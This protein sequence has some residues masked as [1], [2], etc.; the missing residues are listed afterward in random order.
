MKDN[1]ASL[2]V[3]F[4]LK[5]EKYS[6][7]I[8]KVIGN[9]S[10]GITYLASVK[11]EGAL[12]TIE[13]PVALKE[14][15]MRDIN[16]RD[17]VSVTSGSKN[18]IYEEYKKKFV[19]E[20]NNLSKLC[21]PN[22]IKVLES[23]E[24]NNTIYYAMEYI[25]GGDLDHLISTRGVLTEAECIKY[26]IQIA[27]ALK[28]MHANDMLHLD[29][30]PKNIMMRGETPILIDFGLSKQYDENGIPESS[31][32]VGS[33]TDGY[34]PIEQANYHD[35]KDFPVT[36]DIYAF[37][38]TMFKMLTGHRPPAASDILN[39]GFPKEELSKVHCSPATIS[40]IQRCMNPLKKER[41]QTMDDV[42]KTLRQIPG[43][44]DRS[45]GEE[46]KIDV[47]KDGLSAT[48]Q[49]IATAISLK[50]FRMWRDRNWFTNVTILAYMV[51]LW[52]V[53]MLWV[54]IMMKYTY[55]YYNYYIDIVHMMFCGSVVVIYFLSFL[56]GL[57][58]LRNK[59]KKWSIG[60][61]ILCVFI[62]S[63][64]RLVMGIG[65]DPSFTPYPVFS[66]A[67]VFL[68]LMIRRRGL[69]AYYLLGKAIPTA[70]SSSIVS[71]LRN[72]HWLTNTITCLIALGSLLLGAL[73]LWQFVSDGDAYLL[74]IVMCA[75]CSLYYICRNNGIGLVIPP[76]CLLIGFY[77]FYI[78]Q[79]LMGSEIIFGL[80]AFAYMLQ[81]LALLIR[82]NG[83]SA[84]SLMEW[85]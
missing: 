66:L 5:S 25:D 73:Y 69:S 85:L 16:G 68:T 71:T 19:R 47:L 52:I 1:N 30:K 79:H 45:R 64:I 15:F 35:G 37:G 18:G 2:P 12:G 76:L 63:A 8:S 54:G 41:M 59:K 4:K 23:F 72:R 3:G 62:S 17:G 61:P 36:M 56:G 44:S 22:I 57:F 9:G 78:D 7:R 34:A 38:A 6:Y 11:M 14:F 77:L 29:L 81:L 74:S 39:E 80:G 51:W 33:G 65:Y 43:E 83:R 67:F 40:L 46:T 10:F 13:V 49:P 20:A 28:C 24:S 53:M 50:E 48:P 84:L 55:D 58:I 75:L 31:T 60:Y 32:N 70:K 26:S 82:K 21:H 42:L 27:E